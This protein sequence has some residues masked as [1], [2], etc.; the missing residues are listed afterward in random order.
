IAAPFLHREAQ[1]CSSLKPSA[2]APGAGF[3][4]RALD[5][6]RLVRLTRAPLTHPASP[7]PPAGR[8]QKSESAAPPGGRQAAQGPSRKM[9]LR[10]FRQ[11][12]SERLAAG[13]AR[14][15]PST[16]STT[17]PGSRCTGAG[18]LLPRE[19]RPSR[20][21]RVTV[22]GQDDVDGHTPD[23]LLVQSTPS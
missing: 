22:S 23:G 2:R 3:L 11:L 15:T 10:D 12:F 8:R 14:R 1:T 9:L 7:R 19:G 17:A 21:R 18:E 20:R 6:A 4:P 5:P 13:H 16:H